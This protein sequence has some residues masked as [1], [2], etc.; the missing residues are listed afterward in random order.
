VLVAGGCC[1]PG[2]PFVGLASAELYDPSTRSWSL[3][4]SL[5]VARSGHTA[6][7]LADGEVLVAGGTCN[8]SAYGCD[9]GSFLVNLK[10]AEL[11]D[12][13]TGVWTKTG[14]MA[15]GR[16]LHTA[17]LLGNGQVLVTGGFNSCDDDF[18]SD[19][20]EAELYDPATGTWRAAKPMRAA[21]EQ[22]TATLLSD[23][24]VLVAG[25]LDEG[26]FGRNGSTYSSA[27]IYDPTFDR[28]SAAASMNARRFGQSA[29]LLPGGWVL[30]AG[31][32][33]STSEV[34]EPGPALWV[35]V[36]S[37]G[38]TRT[39]HTA[40]LL[41]NGEVLVA[42]GSGPDRQPLS[43]AELY[44]TGAG[45]LVRLSA[46]SLSL[47]T[48]EVRTVGNGVAVTV[49]NFGTAPLD[50]FGAATS[51]ANPGDFF[52]A[53]ACARP[54]APGSSC[55][56]EVR[57]APL[58]PGVRTASVDIADDAPLDPQHVAVRGDAAGPFVWVA[59]GPMSSARS[60]FAATNLLDGRILVAGGYSANVLATAEIYDP[61]TESF[62]PTGSLSTP[63]EFPASAVLADGR[64]LVA[65]GYGP[66]GSINTPLSSA[67]LYDPTTGRW[68]PTGS[69][70]AAS[71]GLTATPLADGSVLVTGFSGSN[72]ELYDPTHGTWSTTGPLPVANEGG[73]TAPL[74]NGEVLLAAGANGTSALYNP[75]T[76]AW[77]TA[78]ST[79]ASH[80][81]GTATT[82]TDGDVLVTGGQSN[83]G[84][85]L[86]TTEL[87]H[88]STGTWTPADNLPAGRQGHSAVLLSNGDVLVAGGCSAACQSSPATDDAYLFANGFW[89]TTGA[90]PTSLYGQQMNLL[91]DGDVLITGGRPDDSGTATA[92]ADRYIQPLITATPARAAPGQTISL[93][94][95][96][97]YA[98]EIV[99][100]T[101]TGAAS[102]L[103]HPRADVRGQ[104]DIT[105]TVPS[106]TGGT[107][108]LQAQGRTS[109]TFAT[110]TLV[111]T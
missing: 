11:Y 101:L 106:V 65:G 74:H 56:I 107:Y 58:Y 69:M 12:P 70:L 21:R 88:P 81:G 44:R 105:V 35:P 23:G 39:G 100:V 83:G 42:G 29:T 50:V 10:S 27:E 78:G 68:T 49:T 84:G 71:D 86:T 25:G 99:A 22:H 28:W 79:A 89:S 46:S 77:T 73:L 7:L 97:F 98:H 96:G 19:L 93:T 110:T 32:G 6:T 109:Y 80:F 111:V 59:T 92:T 61:T 76:N 104:F 26:G 53:S 85:A 60:N 51:G 87:Y 47:P 13:A 16:E 8:G 102:L 45:P 14:S 31:G 108:Q 52:T 5:N 3:T 36:G 94:G 95:N 63:R 2:N 30:V 103:A 91:P 75:S 24:T 55:S 9:A 82:L 33:T 18:C 37:L 41:A 38:T 40:T 66:S 54:V 90:L 67:E 20:R 62:T 57:F 48:Q 4:G 17:T 15:V 1:K 64:V 43:T 72:P 34:Y